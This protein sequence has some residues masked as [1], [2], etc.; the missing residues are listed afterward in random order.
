V[1]HLLLGEENIRVEGAVIDALH[2]GERSIIFADIGNLLFDESACK[3]CLSIKGA[4][5]LFPCIYC[6]NVTTRNLSEHDASGY[7]VDVRC[8]DPRLFDAR[9]DEELWFQ[10]DLLSELKPRL[11]N[12]QFRE[13]QT[14]MGVTFNPDGILWDVELRAF[15][16]PTEVQ[17]YDS[18]HTFFCDGVCQREMS[19][20]LGRLREIGQTYDVIS[21]YFNTEWNF[22]AAMGGRRAPT[23]LSEIFNK[24]R[25]VHWLKTKSIGGSASDMLSVIGP[26]RFYLESN[27]ALFTDLADAIQ[28]YRC[29]AR[30]VR[31]IMDGKEGE[32]VGDALADALQKHADAHFR[33]YPDD[34]PAP[35]WHFARHMP[36]QIDRDGGVIDT[37]PCER[38]QSKVK[39]CAESVDN[40]RNFEKSILGRVLVGHMRLMDAPGCFHDGLVRGKWIPEL[41]VDVST[42]G[43]VN[44]VSLSYGDIVKVDGLPIII[45]GVVLRG[46]VISLIAERF[47]LMGQVTWGH[48]SCG[49]LQPRVCV[50]V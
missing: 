30:V 12:T 49:H 23:I 17:T 16:K 37:F 41:N 13:Q 43:I 9:T 28:S 34:D 7:L 45:L 15:F 46:G 1:R 21:T 35:K 5:G 27:A 22:C 8:G 32:R 50:C 33:A 25:E 18:T 29:M 10:A 40:T 48:Q 11:T 39:A 14:R 42:K 4:S 19:L 2:Q 26:F 3:S 31:F 6:K 47:D 38:Y 36:Q 20:I 44:G 24:A